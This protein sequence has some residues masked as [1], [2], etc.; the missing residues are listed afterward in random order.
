MI[1]WFHALAY[2]QN[3]TARG[4][5][6]GNDLVSMF[7]ITAGQQTMSGQDDDLSGQTFGELVILTGLSVK[8]HFYHYLE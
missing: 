3:Y 6:V 2:Y 4:W 8:L 5:S 7:K 1:V